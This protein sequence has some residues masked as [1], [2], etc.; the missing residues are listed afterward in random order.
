MVI[1]RSQS[2]DKYLQSLFG[3]YFFDNS[4][5]ELAINK[6][7]ELWFENK[8]GWVKI[9]NKEITI[10]NLQYFGNATAQFSSNK[11][12][13]SCPI[14]SATLPNGERLQ[15]IMPPA[16]D[17]GQYSI[18]IRKP[19]FNQITLDDYSK[20]GFFKNVVIGDVKDPNDEVL[21]KYLKNKDYESFFKLAVSCGTK[22]IVI[23]GATGSGKTTFMKSL[24]QHIPLDE[25]L[26]TIEDVR[27]INS[28]H[29]NMV[30]L[31]YP[32][33]KQD[34]VN[35][36]KLLKSSLRMKPDR[37]LL[38][39]LRGG[40]TYDYINVIS[41]GHGG[42]ITSLHAGS[43]SEAI[44]RLVLM[45][46]QNATGSNIPYITLEDLIKNTID[47][48]VVIDNQHGKRYIKTINFKGLNGEPI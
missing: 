19:N 2:V 15:I 7:G 32:S 26:I 12:D 43:Y 41:S 30:N 5:T 23:A 6:V 31:L 13:K 34:I 38:A 47:I 17:D 11:L 24:I 45:T 21:I 22:N 20:S 39:E 35:P 42:S 16:C 44:Q 8:S 36:T 33:E 25:R 28:E 27:E 18:T 10:E 3:D 40:E 1:N 4:I 37:I 14:L 9:A 29:Q 48:I 46:L